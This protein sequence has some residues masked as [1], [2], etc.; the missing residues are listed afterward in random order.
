[1]TPLSVSQI[2]EKASNWPPQDYWDTGAKVV[3]ASIG[4]RFVVHQPMDKSFVVIE[5][6]GTHIKGIEKF[7]NKFAARNSICQL[8][9]EEEE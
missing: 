7:T 1:M 5:F 4:N 6:D 3:S 8:H 9:K 2:A